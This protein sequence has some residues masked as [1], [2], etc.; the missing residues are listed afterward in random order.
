MFRKKYSAGF[1]LIELLVTISIIGFLA[2]ATLIL[3]ANARAKSR[4]GK[5]VGD[6]RQMISGLELYYSHCNSFPVVATPLTLGAAGQ[7]LYNG[8]AAACGTND[9]TSPNG[10]IG[11]AASGT[12]YIVTM[13]SAPLPVD[14]GPTCT[15]ANNP[16]IYTSTDTA[17]VVADTVTPALGFSIDFCIGGQIGTYSAGVKKATISGIN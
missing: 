13:P 16:Y 11:T 5:R 17:G 7:K 1:T 15:S 14:G 6:V 8:T 3:L 4:D 9:G 10:G 12:T 2:A